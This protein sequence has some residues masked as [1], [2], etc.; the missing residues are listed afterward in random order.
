MMLALRHGIYG[1]TPICHL[2]VLPSHSL[3]P[4]GVGDSLLVPIGD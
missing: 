3:R 2:P 1:V 4:S